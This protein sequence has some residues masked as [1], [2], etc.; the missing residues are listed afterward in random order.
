[1]A[2]AEADL[3]SSVDEALADVA[4]RGLAEEAAVAQADAAGE[5]LAGAAL[6]AC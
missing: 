2:Q 3:R 1:V 6:G 5:G 4:A